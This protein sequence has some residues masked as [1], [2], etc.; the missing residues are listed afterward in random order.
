MERDEWYWYDQMMTAGIEILQ[1]LARAKG[2][3]DVIYVPH[4][5][6]K[7]L[8]DKDGAC[9]HMAS[10]IGMLGHLGIFSHQYKSHRDS[11]REFHEGYPGFF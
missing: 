1:D 11:L 2:Y 4:E 8:I 7:R 6:V 9:V 3:A 10:A 5:G